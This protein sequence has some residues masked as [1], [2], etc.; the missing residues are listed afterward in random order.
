MAHTSVSHEVLCGLDCPVL[1]VRSGT[2]SAPFKTSKVLL[3]IAGGDDLGP[4]VR[5]A[6]A[7]ADPDATMMVVH[8][9]QAMSGLHG[10]AYVESGDEI[11][12]TMTHACKLLG[13]AGVIVQGVVAH[14]GP[15]ARAVAEI[16]TS[17]NAD[18]IVVG[19]SRMGDIGSLFLG[20]VSHDL[21]HMTDR[22]VL[23]AE[24]VPA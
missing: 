9:A 10:F 23:V 17:W 8:V 16:A 6:L 15:V 5:A 7:V 22:T 3:A 20:S 14:Q 18:L 12:E 1:I 4:G 2:G 13:D 24:R 19:S 11:H 21:L